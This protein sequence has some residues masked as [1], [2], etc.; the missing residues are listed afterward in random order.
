VAALNL[1]TRAARALRSLK[2]TY[3]YD[4]VQTPPALLFVLPNFGEKS[5]REVKDEVGILGFT[6]GMTLDDESYGAAVVATVAVG[7]QAAKG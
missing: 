4:L 7:I 2:L 1:S 3:V 6:L 5:F